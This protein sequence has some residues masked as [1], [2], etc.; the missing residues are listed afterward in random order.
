MLGEGQLIRELKLGGVNHIGK[1]LSTCQ[2]AYITGRPSHYKK[3]LDPT[4]KI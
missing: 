3:R 2:K 1:K 4:Y